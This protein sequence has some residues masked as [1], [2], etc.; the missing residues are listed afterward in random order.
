VK[1]C[2]VDLDTKWGWVVSIHTSASVI[3]VVFPVV[4]VAQKMGSSTGQYKRCTRRNLCSFRKSVHS[5]AVTVLTEI[6]QV[7]F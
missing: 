7:E 4:P 3:R 2:G 6:T 5:P 1:I